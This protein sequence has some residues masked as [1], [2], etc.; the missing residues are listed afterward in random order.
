[1]RYKPRRDIPLAVRE[2]KSLSPTEICKW[3]RNHR[4]KVDSKTGKRIQVKRK[5]P[6]ISMFFQR[7]PELY[8]QL[9]SE[10]EEEK[11]DETQI[12]ETIFLNGN[13][14]KIPCVEKWVLQLRARGAKES[15]IKNFLGNLR[16]ICL[17]R[18]PR[19]KGERAKP[20]ELIENW[21]LKHPRAL[22]LEDCLRYTS[23]LIKRELPSREHRLTMRNFL[24]SRNVAEWDTIS[25]KLEK[26]KGQYA[27]LYTPKENIE[28]IF[29]WL[30]AVNYDAYLATKF[31]FKC[32]GIRLTATLNA[33]A[34]YVNEEDKTII[35]FEKAN[36]NAPKRRITKEIPDNFFK[37]LLPRIKNG[38]K[39]FKIEKAELTRILRACY[40]AVIPELEANIPM[41]FHFWRHQFAQHM[42]RATDWNYAL[43]ADL[44]GWKLQTLQ[45]YYGAFD[46]KTLKEYARKKLAGI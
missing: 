36:R 45:D 2:L 34:Q 20:Y 43:V 31:S 13:F 29:E 3:V 8:K 15:S 19:K 11:I 39:L 32:G 7:N 22:T 1:M 27:H 26:Q 23:E 16:R 46:R 18:L 25:G 41:P 40:K 12:S 28:K 14:Q 5:P 24:K 21:G 4:T 42:L 9:K 30:K 6:S 35:V 17:G 33:E 10:I 37:E 44:G 38:G